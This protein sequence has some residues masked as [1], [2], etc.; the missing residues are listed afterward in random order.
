VDLNVFNTNKRLERYN[1][2]LLNLKVLSFEHCKWEK[3][4]SE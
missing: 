1:V 4:N 2:N 3:H